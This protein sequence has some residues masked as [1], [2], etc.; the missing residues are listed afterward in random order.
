MASKSKEDEQELLKYR[1]VEEFP[2]SIDPET[3]KPYED[4]ESPR[5]VETELWGRLELHRIA[6]I[7]W[8][9]SVV[10]RTYEGNG[11]EE[12][13][14]IRIYE[15][16]MGEV[17]GWIAKKE[18]LDQYG[19]C[20]VEKGACV[21]GNAYVYGDAVIKK[22]AEIGDFA[23]VGGEAVVRGPVGVG[24]EAHVLGEAKIGGTKEELEEDIDEKWRKGM[25]RKRIAVGGRARVE[26]EIVG[27]S[28]V[29]GSACVGPNAKIEGK[30]KVY[31]GA[32]V[33]GTKEKPAL[34][35]DEAKVYDEAFVEGTVK[36]KAVIC[37]VT[38]LG[39]GSVIGDEISLRNGIIYGEITGAFRFKG[40]YLFLGKG[41]KII[42]YKEEERSNVT[43]PKKARESTMRELVE[44]GISHGT[45]KET[46]VIR[47]GKG[48][49]I[50]YCLLEG[51]VTIE[52]VKAYYSKIADSEVRDSTVDFSV[53]KNSR[54]KEA[55]I[56]GCR[57]AYSQT[58]GQCQ[59][60]DSEIEHGIIPEK[61]EWEKIYFNGITDIKKAK[62]VWGLYPMSG[63][64][65]TKSMLE[66]GKSVKDKVPDWVPLGTDYWPDTPTDYIANVT[67]LSFLNIMFWQRF[68][69]RYYTKNFATKDVAGVRVIMKA[70]R[71]EADRDPPVYD[72]PGGG[73]FRMNGDDIPQ[74]KKSYDD[75]YER[76]LREWW[77]EHTKEGKREKTLLERY[78]KVRKV[79]EDLDKRY[80]A[81]R[82]VYT[83]PAR[84]KKRV[85]GWLRAWASHMA[86]WYGLEDKIWNDVFEMVDSQTKA[87]V[88]QVNVTSPYTQMF[89][90]TVTDEQRGYIPDFSQ[91]MPIEPFSDSYAPFLYTKVNGLGN[92]QISKG[93][94]Q[95][96]KYVYPNDWGFSLFGGMNNL[97]YYIE[98]YGIFGL[99]PDRDTFENIDYEAIWRRYDDTRKELQDEYDA[100]GAKYG[101]VNVE[102]WNTYSESVPAWP[103]SVAKAW[104]AKSEANEKQWKND[105]N[106]LT[107]QEEE[108]A[109]REENERKWE[110]NYKIEQE[111]RKKWDKVEEDKKHVYL[112][113]NAI[114]A[115]KG[116]LW[117]APYT[118]Y[119]GDAKGAAEE[120]KDILQT[121]MYGN[122]G[123][124]QIKQLLEQAKKAS[125]KNKAAW[126]AF[127]ESRDKAKEEEKGKQTENT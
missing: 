13:I 47:I 51:T 101:W 3:G 38:H 2:E 15:Q 68:S 29:Y 16:E 88:D 109:I 102:E 118:S 89:V 92:S 43:H 79:Q 31:G 34:V 111:Y 97:V 44:Y 49:I 80:D 20:W 14:P 75:N 105:W 33:V 86:G 107:R 39:S 115:V 50:K 73:S 22:D 60:L 108:K 100:A 9:E 26:G 84:R 37:G 126:Q 74:A 63:G 117:G 58:S 103:A 96:S 104:Y 45:E 124:D 36:D 110:E 98:Y 52:N 83:E 32:T 93:Y 120:L 65:T 67:D 59:I 127:L 112:R 66:K 4:I 18:N 54:L 5:V 56:N 85:I 25:K 12:E 61:T 125:E 46:D 35:S 28:K 121:L 24:E 119:T 1:F 114:A 77:Y 41:S 6:K 81:I 8:T 55:Q 57:V 64:V 48:C 62:G 90:T 7:K 53:V 70:R 82:N 21:V 123:D 30:A 69:R 42:C 116:Y 19:K 71:Y 72:P 99:H 94:Y 27:T 122:P 23:R 40:L 113:K 76:R 78:D 91:R 10:S 11:K 87:S 95:Y 17:G 106:S